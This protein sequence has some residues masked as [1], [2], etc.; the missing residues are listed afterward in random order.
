MSTTPAVDAATAT[1][2]SLIGSV[3]DNKSA[4][5]PR[6]GEWAISAPMIESAVAAAAMAQDELGHARSTYPVLA[7]LR[8][9]RDDEGLDAGEPAERRAPPRPRLAVPTARRRRRER[10]AGRSDRLVGL[11]RDQASVSP[12]VATCPFCGSTDVETVAAWGGQLI[13]GQVRCQT[14]NTYFE[15]V[16]EAFDPT[17]A[18]AGQG[19]RG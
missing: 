15:V 10:G 5:G 19:D 12:P 8:V 2:I 9:Q 18:G 14:C 16:R 3:A 7:K 17:G 4:L 13:T 11:G 6:Y 1:M